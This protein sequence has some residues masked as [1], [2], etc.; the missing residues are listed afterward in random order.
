MFIPNSLRFEARPKRV[1]SVFAPSNPAP[2]L[3]TSTS[4]RRACSRTRRHAQ[5][6]H[7][8]SAL[9]T[10]VPGGADDPVPALG[11]HACGRV[12]DPAGHLGTASGWSIGFE[13]ICLQSAE[14]SD[15]AQFRQPFVGRTGG[16]PHADPG[17]CDAVPGGT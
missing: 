14:V 1:T 12:P 6:V 9:R 7:A 3:L 5:H 10:G 17:Q 13:M 4:I 2:A 8:I 16:N 11:E 15:L